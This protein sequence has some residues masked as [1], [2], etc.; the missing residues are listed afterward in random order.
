VTRTFQHIYLAP[1]YDDAVFSCG[2]AIHRQA[3]RGESVLVVTVCAAA[4]DPAD[5]LSPLASALHGRMGLSPAAAVARRREEDEAALATLGAEPARLDVPDCIYRGRPSEGQWYYPTLEA[6]FGPAHPEEAAL[7][8]SIAGAVLA[9][10]LHRPGATFYAPLGAGG[11]VD[12]RHVHRA[13]AV[14]A[15][16]GWRVAF[17]E[18]V[19]YADD[20]HPHPLTGVPTPTLE[21]CVVASPVGPLQPHLIPLEEA[22]WQA[23]VA[24]VLAYPSQLPL[25]FGSREAVLP[26]LEAFAGRYAAGQRCERI[27]IPESQAAQAFIAEE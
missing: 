1:H 3:G 9:L 13:A 17:Y 20:T 24:G 14:L 10:D 4:P 25:M 16:Q 7:Y 12:H 8:A 11:H 19:P 22:D 23:R 21:A 27:W 15:G 6:V 5:P 26:R 2:G 18:D